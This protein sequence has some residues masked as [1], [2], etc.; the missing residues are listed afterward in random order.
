MF[1]PDEIIRKNILSLVPYSSARSEYSS[2][3]AILLDANE[4]P[5]NHPYNRYPDPLQRTLKKRIAEILGID[6]C[7]LFLGNGSDEAIDLLFRAFCEP[8]RQNVITMDPSYGMFEVC[9]RINDVALIKIPLTDE[10]QAD[11]NSIL[12][13]VNSSTRLIFFCSP[14]NPTGNLLDR[15][16]MIRIA[17]KFNGLVVVDEAYIDFADSESLI[18]SLV[19]LPNMVILRTFSKAWGMAGI[20]LGMAIADERIIAVLNKIKY[21]YNISMITQRLAAEMLERIDQRDRWVTTIK[22]E[23]RKLTNALQNL[24]LVEKIFPSDANFILVRFSNHLAVLRF[25]IDQKIILRNRSNMYLCEGCLR[26]TIGTDQENKILI[27]KL[28]QFEQINQVLPK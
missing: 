17:E 1:Q 26:I 24:A 18:T 10:F 21:P 23:R 12:Q 11:T 14:N 8:S 6:T 5:F 19:K 25:L 2:G 3:D 27:R 4:N 15:D 28:K 13:A 16:S 22:N 9:A 20:R 7:Q